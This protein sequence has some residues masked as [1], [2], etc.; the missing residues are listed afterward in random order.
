MVAVDHR[1]RVDPP[2]DC[3]IGL[4]RVGRRRDPAM[5]AEKA[6][7]DLEV[8]LDPVMDLADQPALAFERLLHRPLR[9]F[10]PVDRADERRPE[11]LD[12][13]CR[14][15]APRQLQRGPG[16]VPGDRRLHDPQRPNQ[17]YV[18]QQQA[19][20][21]GDQPQQEGQE[22]QQ[23]VAE[24]EPGHHRDGPH[25]EQ[26]VADLKAVFARPLAGRMEVGR[27]DDRDFDAA[28]ADRQLDQVAAGRER[29]RP[30][31]VLVERA[32]RHAVADP[33]P[34]IDSTLGSPDGPGV[35]PEAILPEQFFRPSAALPPEK[36]LM[37]AVL[38]G[39]LLDLQRSAGARTPRA[40]RLR[41]E[42]DAWFA[43]D[44]EDWP[45]S[46]VNLCYALGLDASAVRRR[47]APWRRMALAKGV[48]LP[49]ESD[50]GRHP[51]EQA[52]NLARAG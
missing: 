48:S 6:G 35:V 12:L 22:D 43:A 1:Q 9:L 40:R 45:F 14:A 18:D 50:A 52:Q 41:D 32:G 20:Q 8:V 37:L 46:F 5:Q 44:G 49:V 34:M 47:L 15:H 13:G 29:R 30:H 51:A 39:A 27:A 17:Q 33:D 42:V 21:G 11:I 36:R 26:V 24:P 10:D 4:A 2:A 23:P 7:D 3:R 31:L 38:E 28:V 16:L 19:E 25:L